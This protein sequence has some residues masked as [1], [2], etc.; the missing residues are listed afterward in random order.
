[1][2]HTARPKSSKRRPEHSNGFMERDA[3]SGPGAGGSRPEEGLSGE[4][5]Q[6]RLEDVGEVMRIDGL[7]RTS[8]PF[9]RTPVRVRTQLLDAPPACAVDAR[10]LDRLEGRRA[11][12]PALHAD[13]EELVLLL[14]PPTVEVERGV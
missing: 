9:V 13:G 6:C 3:G 4:G 1:M 8:R 7:V 12:R 11:R 2:P 10:G 5:D 14:D